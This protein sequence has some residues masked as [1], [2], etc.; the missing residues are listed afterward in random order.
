MCGST[1]AA[2]G[3]G[4]GGAGAGGAGS[5]GV[6][7]GGTGAGGGGSGAGI[8]TGA[9]GGLTKTFLEGLPLCFAVRQREH[10]HCPDLNS[11]SE[12]NS[13]TNSS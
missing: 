2:G 5:G 7:A 12:L 9:V 13:L 11:G 3:A 1:G 4:A 10:E 8:E 6:G